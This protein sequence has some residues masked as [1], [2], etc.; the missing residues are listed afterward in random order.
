MSKPRGHWDIKE[1][2][3]VEALKYTTRNDFKKGSGGAYE[4]T[5]RNGWL[6]EFYP[7]IISIE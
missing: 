3:R 7:K 6:D 5:R 1:N 4:V 2:C